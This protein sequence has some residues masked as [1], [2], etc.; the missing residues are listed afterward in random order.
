M[1]SSPIMSK[2]TSVMELVDMLYLG[3]KFCGFKSHQR[4]ISFIYKVDGREVECDGLL[5]H[6]T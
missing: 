3:C 4:Y 5:N 2:K 6:Y 1:G